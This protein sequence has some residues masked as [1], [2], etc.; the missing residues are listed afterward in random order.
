M[1]LLCLFVIGESETQMTLSPGCRSQQSYDWCKTV[2]L[3]NFSDLVTKVFLVRFLIRNP[4][5]FFYFTSEFKA[6]N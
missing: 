2:A 5:Y 3:A 1:T 6:K 4:I